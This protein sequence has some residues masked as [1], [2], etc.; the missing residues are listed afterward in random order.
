MIFD[1]QGI[2]HGQVT[3]EELPGGHEGD[4]AG[5][6]EG[7]CAQDIADKVLCE[8][9]VLPVYPVETGN[10]IIR[11][12]GEE[13]GVEPDDVD[14]TDGD[15]GY[16]RVVV[17]VVAGGQCK[18]KENGEDEEASEGI[19]VTGEGTLVT[20]EGI[21]MTGRNNALMGGVCV[22]VGGVCRLEMVLHIAK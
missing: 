3:D 20:G 4:A 8:K 5:I 12:K 18:A 13:G 19:L 11:I 6:G 2:F 22:V 7:A 1:F 9:R 17:A 16:I 21:L 14:V 10:D 15:V